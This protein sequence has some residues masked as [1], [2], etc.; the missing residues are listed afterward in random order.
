[1]STYKNVVFFH[2]EIFKNL[3]SIPIEIEKK[4]LE[5]L[6]KDDIQIFEKQFNGFIKKPQIENIIYK[7]LSYIKQYLPYYSSETVSKT[8]SYMKKF[9]RKINRKEKKFFKLNRYTHKEKENDFRENYF[10]DYFKDYKKYDILYEKCI[11]LSDYDYYENGVYITNL[12]FLMTIVIKDKNN[13]IFLEFEKYY[14]DSKHERKQII[15]N[16]KSK[17]IKH[18]DVI[19]IKNIYKKIKNKNLESD[20]SHIIYKKF[21]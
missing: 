15:V 11:D 14:D 10:I 5:Y 16:S 20:L 6:S 9:K 4:I 13:Y 3:I 21:I 2:Y 18:S 7:P 12:C 8:N 19:Y 17:F 1:M